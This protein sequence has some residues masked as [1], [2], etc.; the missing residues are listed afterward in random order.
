M[1]REPRACK[2]RKGRAQAHNPKY[3]CKIMEIFIVIFISFHYVL[4]YAP[5]YADR[6]QCLRTRST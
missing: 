3:I 2:E 6:R 5:L 4:Y 1:A